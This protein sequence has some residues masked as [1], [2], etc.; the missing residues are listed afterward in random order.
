MQAGM[1]IRYEPREYIQS[2]IMMSEKNFIKG[3][4]EWAP[5]IK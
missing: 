2:K 4:D 3:Q 5:G 1:D